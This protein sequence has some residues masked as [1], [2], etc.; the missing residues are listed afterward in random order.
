MGRKMEITAL[1]TLMPS[2]LVLKRLGIFIFLGCIPLYDYGNVLAEKF[3]LCCSDREE[4]GPQYQMHISL[5]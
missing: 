3:I 4:P 1:F 2:G 5:L